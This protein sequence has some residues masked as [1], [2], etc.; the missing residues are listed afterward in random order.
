MAAPE[1]HIES[2]EIS[3]R[4]VSPKVAQSAMATLGPALEQA[5]AAQSFA[6]DSAANQPVEAGASPVLRVAAGADATTLR[7]A[8]ARH[9]AMMISQ[10]SRAASAGDSD[11]PK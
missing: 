2:V 5:L 3:V 7:G 4:G 11:R 1:I 8:V 10:Q 6:P 9:L